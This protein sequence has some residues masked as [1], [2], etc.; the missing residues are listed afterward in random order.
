MVEKVFTLKMKQIEPVAIKDD[1]VIYN[2]NPEFATSY[3]GRV[4][5]L[6]MKIIEKNF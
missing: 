2:V 6:I 5:V 4:F 3:F 1:F